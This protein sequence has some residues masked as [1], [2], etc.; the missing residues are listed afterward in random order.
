MS[1]E[2]REPDDERD[3]GGRG[4]GNIWLKILKAIAVGIGL[5]AV[6][7]VLLV[8]LALGACFLGARR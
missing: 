1:E 2:F 5:L 6:V 4:S 3:D 7:A 8:G